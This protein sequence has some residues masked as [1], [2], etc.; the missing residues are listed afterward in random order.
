MVVRMRKRRPRAV[1]R[2]LRKQI[3]QTLQSLWRMDHKIQ[4]AYTDLAFELTDV[5]ETLTEPIRQG[6]SSAARDR[7]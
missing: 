2:W 3:R 5:E 4:E 6:Y 7:S 1:P